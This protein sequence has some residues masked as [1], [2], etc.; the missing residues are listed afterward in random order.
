MVTADG[1]KVV[2]F[3]SRFGDPEAQVV[4]PLY[5]GDIVELLLAASDG[6][7]H[8]IHTPAN[9]VSVGSA[10]CVVLASAG[11]PDNYATG[12]EVHGLQDLPDGVV[13]FH[14][15]TK[16]NSGRIVTSGGRVLGVTAISPSADLERTIRSAYEGVARI[17]FEGMHFRHDIGRKALSHRVMTKETI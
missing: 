5:Q 4:L 13:A 6:S 16:T 3:N 17:D 2:E 7:I 12:K 11:Y 15:G 9:T 1:P 8:S 14:A 10:V